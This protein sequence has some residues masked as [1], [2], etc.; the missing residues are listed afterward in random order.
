MITKKYLLHRIEELEKEVR[1]LQYLEP[2]FE[3]GKLTVSYDS[4]HSNS[5]FPLIPKKPI[6]FVIQAILDYLGLEF[7]HQTEKYELTKKG[8]TS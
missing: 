3:V 7:H 4:N 8:E 6:S 2:Q 5:S 1:T